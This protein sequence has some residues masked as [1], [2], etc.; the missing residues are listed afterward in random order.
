MVYT[1]SDAKSTTRRIYIL[2]LTMHKESIIFLNLML[3]GP[4]HQ[5]VILVVDTMEYISVPLGREEDSMQRM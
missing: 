3:L 4:A 5:I 1:A 2:T